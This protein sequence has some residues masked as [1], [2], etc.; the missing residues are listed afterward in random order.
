LHKSEERFRITFRFIA[1]DIV[2]NFKKNFFVK[3]F[4]LRRLR[5]EYEKCEKTKTNS[6]G[7]SDVMKTYGHRVN[8]LV[9]MF[10]NQFLSDPFE[11]IVMQT[12]ATIQKL[13]PNHWHR[14]YIIVYIDW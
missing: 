13:L 11:L 9:R 12:S 10:L 2:E 4:N 8:N 14:R 1:A 5:K 6:Q 3:L 7:K